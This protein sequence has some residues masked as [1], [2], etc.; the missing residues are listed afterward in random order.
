MLTQL[1]GQISKIKRDAHKR[2][3]QNDRVRQLVDEKIAQADESE[4]SRPKRG[5]LDLKD[6][7]GNEMEL[8]GGL[9]ADTRTRSGRMSKRL[10]IGRNG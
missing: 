10:G 7:D 5:A 4:K 6:D 1:H 8:D 2:G 3:Q 9:M